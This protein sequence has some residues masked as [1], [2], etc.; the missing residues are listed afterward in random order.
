MGLVAN[1][2]CRC[3]SFDGNTGGYQVDARIMSRTWAP[4]NFRP[5]NS[6][7]YDQRGAG[8]INAGGPSAQYDPWL[9]PMPCSHHPMNLDMTATTATGVV[10]AAL[11]LISST[12]SCPLPAAAALKA[13]APCRAAAV[14]ARRRE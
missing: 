7:D 13:L 9:G 6:V 5:R 12:S 8:A 10:S 3:G 14:S 2:A 4:S 11:C 1:I